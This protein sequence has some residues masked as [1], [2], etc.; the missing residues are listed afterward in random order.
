MLYLRAYLLVN[1]LLKLFI[2][3]DSSHLPITV[4]CPE[5]C[6][7]LH[8]RLTHISP[9]NVMMDTSSS[10]MSSYFVLSCSGVAGISACLF[11]RLE[12]VSLPAALFSMKESSSSAAK[13]SISSSNV[14]SKTSLL[15]LC[16]EKKKAVIKEYKSPI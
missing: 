13:L 16:T 5:W 11:D 6:C 15:N 12:I 1:G 4:T 9:R 8:L 10:P 14:P 2:V 7:N 3:Q